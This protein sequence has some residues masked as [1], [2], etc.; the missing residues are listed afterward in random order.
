MAPYL[1][2][3]IT[4]LPLLGALGLLLARGSADAVQASSRWVA[5]WTSLV[6][7]ALSVMM[8]LGFDPHLAGAQFEVQHAWMPAFGVSYHAGVDGISLV[9]VLL[10]TFL[11]PLSIAASWTLIT[12]RVRDYM[13][14]VLLLETTLIGLFSAL[15]LVVFYIFYEATLI[16]G[17]LMIGIW[18]GPRRIWASLQF[19][20][21]TFGGSLFMLLAL[22]AMWTAAG[23]TDIPALMQVNVP[24]AMQ[25][26]LLL[27]FLIAFGVKLP[28][29]PL[30][31]WLPDAYTEAPAPATALLSGVLSKAGAYG[32]L[33][34]GVLMFPE[35]AHR[36]APYV[37]VLGVVAVIYAAII[38]LAQTDMKRTIAY[39][40]FSHMGLIAVGLFSLD[41]A[42]LDGAIFQMLSHGV[43]IVALFLCIAAIAWRTETRTID[44]MGGV[45]A[46]MPKLAALG[47]L[48][49][50]ANVGLPGTGAFVGEW[51]V[52]IGALHVSFW[53][54]LFAGSA[55]ILGAVYT[56]VLYRRV[57]FGAVKGTAALLRDLTGV[58][59]AVLVPL[60]IVTLW[61]GIHPD[62][63]LRLFDP[64]ITSAL[65]GHAANTASVA[66]QAVQV[67]AR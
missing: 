11:T 34:L 67:A 28:L 22:I 26:W 16:P 49:I 1:L 30:H 42:G 21:F 18:G 38:A 24:P 64:V 31:A 59:L 51:L 58:E 25:N 4:F 35:A 53:V 10:T 39:S 41:P 13:I 7:F 2:P 50:M 45:A 33:R 32:M 47:M 52:M 17:S 40:S 56:L 37:L 43:V 63:F 55:M 57:M 15:D 48:F 8:W 46:R 3:L 62:T 29:F 66:H 54:A 65:G 60:A 19:F 6:V 5:L 61:M 36:F 20:L 12:T 9:F 23:T 44:E 14:A 27:G